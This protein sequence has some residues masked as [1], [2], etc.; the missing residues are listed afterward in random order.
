MLQSFCIGWILGI[1]FMGFRFW[2]PQLSTAQLLFIVLIWLVLQLY[3]SPKLK[4]IF[5]KIL[6]L[7]T[8][9]CIGS[10]LGFSFANTQLDQRLALVEHQSRQGEF[11]AYIPQISQLKDQAIQQ[12]IEVLNVNQQIQYFM[13]YL[14]NSILQNNH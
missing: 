6:Q 4:S 8:N 14:P 10:I 7:S 11:I 1:S 12:K 2:N 13:A 9:L 3:I 5:S